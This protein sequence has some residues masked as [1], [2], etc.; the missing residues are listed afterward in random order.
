MSRE[1]L[2]NAYDELA[3]AYAQVAHEL[4][5]VDAP[6][7]SG[8]SVPPRAPAPAA[9]PPLQDEE[10]LDTVLS[11]T[12]GEVVFDKNVCPKHRVPFEP[13]TYGPFCKQPTDDPAWG[14]V[15][16]DRMWCKLTPKNA[17]QW[18]AIQEAGRA[19]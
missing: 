4:R 2:A 12:G 7:Q 16:G 13:G 5:G 1:R 6:G 17:P 18:L 8:E 11:A 9:L 10:V 19:A 3:E 14:K 15:K